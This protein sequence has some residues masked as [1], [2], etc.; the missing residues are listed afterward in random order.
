MRCGILE[1]LEMPES[2]AHEP[3]RANGHRRRLWFNSRSNVRRAGEGGGPD[4]ETGKRMPALITKRFK[5]YSIDAI[6]SN[7]TIVDASSPRFLL[8]FR[9]QLKRARY[10]NIS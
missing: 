8:D 7:L 5:A 2:E 6:S 4:R 1:A 3:R 9:T 10:D